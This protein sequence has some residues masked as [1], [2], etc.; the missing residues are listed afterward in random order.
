VN[1]VLVDL[2]TVLNRL[3]AEE[4]VW[5]KRLAELENSV[6]SFE[7]LDR[8]QYEQ[9]LRLELG[10]I[11]QTIEE[12]YSRVQERRIFARRIVELSEKHGL[13]PREAL[14]LVMEADL[15]STEE[16]ERR[17]AE[18]ESDSESDEKTKKS[19]SETKKDPWSADE[20]EARRRAKKETKR[21]ARR[22]KFQDKAQAKA[23]EKLREEASAPG[24]RT[25]SARA[26]PE[27]KT[28]HQIITLYRTL[29]RRLHPDSPEIIRSIS[30]S[31]L[32]AIWYE[33]QEA[34]TKKSL[35]R[36][37]AIAA[38]L[39]ENTF[40]AENFSLAQS[41]LT[42]S[43]RYDRMKS[44]EKSCERIQKKINHLVDHPAWDF[45]A[46]TAQAKKKLRVAA[47]QEAGEELGKVQ[48][49]L[50]ELGDFIDSIGPPR[51][52]KGNKIR[53]RER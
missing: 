21:E 1:L 33:V 41:A 32:S 17:K 37:L 45:T 49:I 51:P 36:M 14:F 43:E 39:E 46:L 48:E 27:D 5:S 6:R 28:R 44:I 18:K 8:P 52:P 7:D 20:I 25:Q 38:W 31:R 10:P 13:H 34:Y 22:E 53:R 12:L 30:P 23:E 50:A 2:E 42:V 24:A 9:W 15:R 16:R 26:K 4:R 3:Q 47:S 40:G 29:V 35:E 19:D 11:L